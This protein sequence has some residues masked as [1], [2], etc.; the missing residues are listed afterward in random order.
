MRAQIMLRVSDIGDHSHNVGNENDPVVRRSRWL[1]NSFPGLLLPDQIWGEAIKALRLWE[2][3]SPTSLVQDPVFCRLLH[4]GVWDSCESGRPAAEVTVMRHS[5]N[6]S[7]RLMLC[8][9]EQEEKVSLQV[10]QRLLFLTRRLHSTTSWRGSGG[11]SRRRCGT[12]SSTGLTWTRRPWMGGPTVI[13]S[14]LTIISSGSVKQKSSPGVMSKGSLTWRRTSR[15]R[16]FTSATSSA[17]WPISPGGS[18]RWRVS[19]VDTTRKTSRSR[20]SK[21][22]MC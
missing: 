16:R 18:M 4:N 19:S 14:S 9:L 7:S 2:E 21:M 20:R 15:R 8:A 22:M 11:H 3:W 6:I 13:E 10:I 17:C 1:N 12:L 5:A